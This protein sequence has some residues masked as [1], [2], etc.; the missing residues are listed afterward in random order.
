M[1]SKSTLKEFFK[2]TILNVTGMIGLSCYILADTFFVS[3]GLGMTGLAAL[4]LAIPVF[5]F[6]H[7]WGL[8]LGMGGATWYSIFRGRQ[9]QD[10][11][12]SIFT[13]MLWM[14][15]VM[16]LLFLLTGVFLSDPLTLLLGADEE[17]AAMT[18]TYLRVL[19]LFS[20]AFMMNDLLTCFVRN[21]GN[22]RL[23]MLSMLLGSL[24]NIVLDYLFIFPLHMGIL[25]AVLAT[26]AAPLVGMTILSTHWFQKQNGFHLRKGPLRPTAILSGFSLGVSSLITEM[27]SGI[28]IIVFNIIIL[29]LTGNAGVAAYGVIA[30]LSLVVI[31]IYTGIAQG[32][33]PLTSQAYGKGDN[34]CIR[35][36]LH[37][38][39]ITVL[40]LSAGIYSGLFSFASPI[41]Q[42]FNS[43]NNPLLQKI[44]VTGMK[45][46]FTAIP[47]AGINI[48]LSLFFTSTDRAMPAQLISAARGFGVI[49]PAA[50]LLS[51]LAGMMG[52][53]LAFPLTE[54]VVL[55]L[56]AV[57]LIGGK[58]LPSAMRP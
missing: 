12:D 19:L 37:Y 53:W 30:N 36:L 22:P 42:I 21:D 41:V 56:G 20:P 28:V 17:T 1:Y 18:R 3:K 46:Y 10:S 11:C 7:G 9:E 45:L 54:C 55:A 8:M 13:H 47:F 32:M 2:Y 29:G 39:L 33:Q 23:S 4:N 38:G 26:G 44:A 43:E 48:V 16:S 50:F 5:S 14:T 34:A 51:R 40:I 52:V 15:L 57:C 58:S 6:I 49:I 24:S 35:Q 31:S 27:S 25:G